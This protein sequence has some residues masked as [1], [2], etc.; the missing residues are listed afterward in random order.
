MKIS[1]NDHRKIFAVKEEFSR[2]FPYLTLEFHG[3]PEKKDGPSSKKMIKHASKTIGECRVIH[4]KGSLTL[5]PHLTVAD[6]EETFRDVFGLSV[7][8]YRKTG[9]AW[10]EISLSDKWTLEQQNKLG[11]ELS[12]K[13]Y[14]EEDQAAE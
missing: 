5:T 13:G 11:E 10:L 14:I 7:I 9:K 3:K 1:I 6:L 4:K 12:E 8:V 2:F